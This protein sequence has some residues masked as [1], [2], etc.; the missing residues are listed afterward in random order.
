MATRRTVSYVEVLTPNCL[1][2]KS[3]KAVRRYAGDDVGFVFDPAGPATSPLIG[4]LT[5]LNVVVAGARSAM[6]AFSRSWRRI[7]PRQAVVA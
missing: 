7:S 4:V 3:L 6:P 5:S 2:A 1:R